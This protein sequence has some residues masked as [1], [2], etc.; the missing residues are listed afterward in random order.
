ME[1]GTVLTIGHSTN[2]VDAF[3]ALVQRHGV[4]AVA[5]VR[6]VPYSR[7]NPDFNR[8]PL[9][10]SLAVHRVAYV[11]LGRELGG[12]PDDP[13][14]YDGGRVSYERVGATAS[15]RRGLDRVV[16]GAARRRIV[17]MC[18]EREPLQC[19]RALLVA[20]ALVA[21]GV[22]VGHILG[23]GRL[24]THAAAM[25]RLLAMQGMSDE[26]EQRSLFS[27]HRD[28]RIRDAIAEQAKRVG[29]RQRMP[30]TATGPAG[31]RDGEG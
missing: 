24:E 27:R 19:H 3:L 18:A 7:F 28:E 20:P 17:L 2:A 11:F 26:V 1:G 31:H 16:R 10:R 14:C 5:D 13:S 4:G 21:R 15:F 23:D 9:A 22:P 6:S 8:E 25:D 12:R 29:A 30:S